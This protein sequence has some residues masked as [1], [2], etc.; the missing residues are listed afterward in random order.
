VLKWIDFPFLLY[1]LC[2]HSA[3]FPIRHPLLSLAKRAPVKNVFPPAM[4]YY[5]TGTASTPP[6]R[7]AKRFSVFAANPSILLDRVAWHTE[8]NKANSAM[9]IPSMRQAVV[10][11]RRGEMPCRIW[12]WMAGPAPRFGVPCQPVYLRHSVA[13]RATQHVPSFKISRLPLDA[14]GATPWITSI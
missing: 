8:R 1:S 3:F 7:K 10:R 13:S 2:A 12:I 6:R 5:S 14:D 11:R 9:D 4:L